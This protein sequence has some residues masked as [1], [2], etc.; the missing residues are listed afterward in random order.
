VVRNLTD[1]VFLSNVYAVGGT[2][3]F[4]AVSQD[5][6]MLDGDVAQWMGT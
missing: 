6:A 5:R 4:D 3:T 1:H 2:Q